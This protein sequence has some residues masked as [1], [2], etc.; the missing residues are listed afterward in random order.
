V[1]GEVR[2]DLVSV[3]FVVKTLGFRLGTRVR[4][5]LVTLSYSQ[6]R[7]GCRLGFAMGFKSDL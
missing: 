7:S 2:L 4:M 6:V 1:L 5:G 3:G